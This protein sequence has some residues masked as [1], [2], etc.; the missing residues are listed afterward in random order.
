MDQIKIAM[1]HDS[2]LIEF[3]LWHCLPTTV[4]ALLAQTKYPSE[5]EKDPNCTPLLLRRIATCSVVPICWF[6]QRENE[7][8]SALVGECEPWLDRVVKVLESL[9]TI[10][11]VLEIPQTTENEEL[12]DWAKWISNV[13]KESRFITS[14]VLSEI[15]KGECKY[16]RF[17]N[18]NDWELEM[19]RHAILPVLEPCKLVA[20]GLAFLV[21]IVEHS[22]ERGSIEFAATVIEHLAEEYEN[23]SGPANQ[24]R[25]HEILFWCCLLRR[26][27]AQGKGLNNDE[28][29][30]WESEKWVYGKCK[31]EEEKMELYLE[32]LKEPVRLPSRFA[33]VVLK[34]N[35]YLDVLKRATTYVQSSMDLQVR[36]SCA[37]TGIN[38]LGERGSE[39]A[40]SVA[41]GL[42]ELGVVSGY[43]L[44]AVEGD[45]KLAVG[46]LG[47]FDAECRAAMGVCN[48]LKRIVDISISKATGIGP[49]IAHSG[50]LLDGVGPDDVDLRVAT[51]ECTSA[52]QRWQAV[53]HDQTHTTDHVN[54]MV[55]SAS[56]I[57]SQLSEFSYSKECIRVIAFCAK[58]LLK[59]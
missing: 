19:R 27:E 54:A 30:L 38:S 59:R 25:G 53:R 23:G 56:V 13:S 7:I 49:F 44:R 8:M 32:R 3:V 41:K 34:V 24:A 35:L 14:G 57:A 31:G 18:C 10:L 15:G 58:R 11:L 33:T 43:E 39:L 42:T 2:S 9:S 6:V 45:T 48:L 21:N 37:V 46:Y 22:N 1:D 36:K 50:I 40:R 20:H 47:A 52:L 4:E 12:R 55:A 29:S 51:S 17:G 5:W 26:F 16:P 28:K